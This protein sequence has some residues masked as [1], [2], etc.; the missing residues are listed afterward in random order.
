MYLALTVL[1]EV[2]LD[3]LHPLECNHIHSS[4]EN[5][6]HTIY[7]QKLFLFYV[8]LFCAAVFASLYSL[9]EYFYF[10][11]SCFTSYILHRERYRN[12]GC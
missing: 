5:V 3:S 7:S 11:V 6:S 10:I 1:R 8:L 12:Q 4:Y 2:L 9:L